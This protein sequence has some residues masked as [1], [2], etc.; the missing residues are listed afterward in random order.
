MLQWPRPDT[1]KKV[2]SL[3][4]LINFFRR[5]VP[6]I[7]ELVAPILNIKGKVFK[8]EEQLGA[9]QAYQNIY[10]AL[11]L[12]KVFLHFP[13]DGVPLELATDASF[14]GIGGVLFQVVNDNIH[15]IGFNSRV[16]RNAEKRYSVPKKEL[17]SILYHVKH[18]RE[19]LLGAPFKLH[20]DAKALTMLFQDLDRPKKN[21]TLVSWLADLAEYD[22]AMYHIEGTKNSLADMAS[23]LHMVEIEEIPNNDSSPSMDEGEIE[24]L[25]RE[26][27]G[28]GHWGAT[29]MYKH[30]VHTLHRHNI[31]GLLKRCQEYTKRCAACLRVNN[32]YIPFAAPRSPEI[33]LPMQYV[34]FD[35][36]EMNESDRGYKYALVMVDGM[37]G[38]VLVKALFAKEMEEVA[39]D[40]LDIFLTF[41]FPEKIK[42]DNGKEFCNQVVD[43]LLLKAK[44]K[45]NRTVAHDHHANG[46]VERII[47]SVRSMLEKFKRSLGEEKYR[48]NW[49]L[50]LP[51]VQFGLNSRIHPVTQ[52]APFMLMFGRSSFYEKIPSAVSQ[53][54][55]QKKLQEFWKTFHRD[56]PEAIF[57]M[58]RYKRDHGKYHHKTREF[59]LG[60]T[61][62]RKLQE[63]NK[64]DDKYT[65][66]YVVIDKLESGNLKVQNEKEVVE[67]PTNFL[68]PASKGLFGALGSVEEPELFTLQDLEGVDS[69]RDKSYVPGVNRRKV[70]KRKHA[71]SRKRS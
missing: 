15:Y 56:L 65:G 55:S 34:Y 30:I 64:Q 7:T 31:P 1:R 62:F 47:R 41:G 36:M 28:V 8:W 45:H 25:L 29:L 70:K 21:T 43:S 5:F 69:E 32:N 54:E 6:H 53:E 61:V 50:L 16:L 4:G 9:E 63:S 68:K 39:E 24:K 10:K 35:L 48:Q 22:F 14:N 49:E 33:L 58:K 60:E 2:Q 17:I 18:F 42:T 11:V 51:L 46:T 71:N 20:T 57:E 67:V 38:F 23:R 66:P 3:L 44:V 13:I 27:H 12:N 52:C 40:I 59:E 19:Y 37:S 26:T